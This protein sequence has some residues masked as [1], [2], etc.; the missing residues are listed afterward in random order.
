M[1]APSINRSPR[2]RKNFIKLILMH[3][4]KALVKITIFQ[5]RRKWRAIKDIN[6]H[7]FGVAEF[8]LNYAIKR[9]AKRN[10]HK[11]F[12]II[13]FAQRPLRLR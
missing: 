7:K 12:E 9:V 13:R 3:A 8:R 6:A 2:M 1:F 10:S 11:K 5:S 4:I